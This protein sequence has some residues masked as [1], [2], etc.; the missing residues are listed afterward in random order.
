MRITVP[1][2]DTTKAKVREF[3]EKARTAPTF[4]EAAYFQRLA[5]NESKK[6]R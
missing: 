4:G 6:G 1:T 5:R 2:Y 3:L